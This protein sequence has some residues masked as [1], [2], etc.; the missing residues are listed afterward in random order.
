MTQ[1]PFLREKI[2]P[3]DPL[4]ARS[5]A[6]IL[7]ALSRCSFQ[8]RA[9]AEA[10]GVWERMC[11]DDGCFRVMTLA[12]AM[13]PAGMGLLVIRLIEAGLVHAIVCTGATVSHDVANSVEEG[14]QAHYLGRPDADD[15]HLRKERINRVYDTYITEV[16]FQRAEKIVKGLL[17]KLAF[18]NVG[19]GVHVITTHS[20]CRQLGGLLP[21]RGIL[22]AAAKA[23]VPIYIPA[24]ADSELGLDVINGN[25]EDV[26]GKGHRLVFD[27]LSEVN[28]FARRLTGSPRGGIVSVGGG[29][30]R[31]WA[32]QIYPYLDMKPVEVGVKTAGYHYGLRITTDR[33]EFGGLS[34]CTISESKSWG[35]YESEATHASVIC[36]ATIALPLLV[37]ALLE[38]LGPAR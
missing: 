14:G 32:Q 10:L 13:V 35:K 19:G 22:A 31:N 38:R 12:G 34:G 27:T 1:D 25:D 18:D 33:A 9:M 4:A 29:V 16:A 8:G 21:G 36:D 7:D 17:P 26:L 30:P 6:E 2:T 28:D 3:F 11:R 5:A 23:D 15:V 37:T 20:F 24:I